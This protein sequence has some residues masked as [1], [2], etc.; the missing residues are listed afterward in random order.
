[1]N[2]EL[3]PPK[4]ACRFRKEFVP[5]VQAGRHEFFREATRAERR[6]LEKAEHAECKKYEASLKKKKHAKS[7]KGGKDL[8]TAKATKKNNNVSAAAKKQPSKKV[9]VAKR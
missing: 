7:K 9:N 6:A 8:K 3:T 1:M 5:V 2:A 4:N